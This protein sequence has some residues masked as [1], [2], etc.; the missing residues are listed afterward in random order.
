MLEPVAQELVYL[1]PEGG[2]DNGLLFWLGI[3]GIVVGVLLVLIGI[4]LPK[5]G[6]PEPA[7]LIRHG[8]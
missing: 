8:G 2:Q 1:M 5:K 6:P 7:S 3:A 4:L